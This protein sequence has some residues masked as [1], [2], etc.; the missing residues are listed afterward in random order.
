M[1]STSNEETIALLCPAVLDQDP[2]C[3]SA[4]VQIHFL[5]SVDYLKTVVK[6]EEVNVTRAECNQM[7][8]CGSGSRI[9]SGLVAHRLPFQ[10]S[11]TGPE[12]CS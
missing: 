5:C 8:I 11:L 10:V 7:F 9:I 3:L 4:F 6:A 1:L 2:E 12:G